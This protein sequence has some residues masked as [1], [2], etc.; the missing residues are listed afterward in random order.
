EE[1]VYAIITMV[2]KYLSQVQQQKAD[3]FMPQTLINPQSKELDLGKIQ[4][5]LDN[6]LGKNIVTINET[7]VGITQSITTPKEV[8]DSAVRIHTFP[9]LMGIEDYSLLREIANS[10]TRGRIPVVVAP[11]N[12]INTSVENLKKLEN[13]VAALRQNASL[14]SDESKELDTKVEKLNASKALEQARFVAINDISNYQTTEAWAYA[15]AVVKL[16]ILQAA[17]KP[18]MIQNREEY[19]LDMQKL[20]SLVTS[21][22]V[23]FKSLS[24]MLSYS[25]IPADM[26]P[27]TFFDLVSQVVDKLLLDMKIKPLRELNEKL[28]AREATS[29]SA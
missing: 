8:T 11:G 1:I 28:I 6:I 17:L 14:T 26:K 24:L 10:I 29:E 3:I 4:E 25:A 9:P 22:D 13:E 21:K 16:A 18:E 5:T 27:A 23:D 20:M 7:A 19:A 12:S 15:K 2:Q